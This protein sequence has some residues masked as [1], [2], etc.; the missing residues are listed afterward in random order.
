M[1]NATGTTPRGQAAPSQTGQQAGQSPAGQRNDVPAR[2]N[3]QHS[4]VSDVMSGAMEQAAGQVQ[5]VREKASGQL[6]QRMGDQLGQAG[7]Q[8]DSI[9]QAL[10]QA[11]TQLR[12]QGQDQ[13]ATLVGRG[14]Q[15]TERIASYLQSTDADRLL[16]DVEDFGRRQPLLMAAGGLVAGFAASRFMKASSQRRLQRRTSGQNSSWGAAGQSGWNTVPLEAGPY[17]SP[18]PS[19]PYASPVDAWTPPSSAG[20]VTVD[21]TADDPAADWPAS[22]MTDP[23]VGESGMRGSESGG[24][25][26]TAETETLPQSGGVNDGAGSPRRSG[27]RRGAKTGGS[28][29]RSESSI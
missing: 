14:V 1:A 25:L 16:S 8:A 4:G 22:P 24:G 2:S 28:D 15:T 23:W 18:V 5:N 12:D 17:A 19:G 27:G 21:L 13:A 20:P 3:E 9:A 10:R 11:Q 7:Q 26:S 29:A 6:R